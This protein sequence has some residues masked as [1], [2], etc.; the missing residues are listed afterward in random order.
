MTI[1]TAEWDAKDM[2][3]YKKEMILDLLHLTREKM[4][5]DAALQHHADP[6]E[7][8]LFTRIYGKTESI[9]AS[10][11]EVLEPSIYTYDP[12]KIPLSTPSFWSEDIKL[13]GVVGCRNPLN[14]EHRQ[15]LYL[16]TESETD[17]IGIEVAGTGRTLRFKRKI[18]AFPNENRILKSFWLNV[19][20]GR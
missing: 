14:V 11:E 12:N 1:V 17:E 6:S 18:I 8:I 16:D 13:V 4:K 10:L 5:D 9:R 3:S 15:L 20:E 19:K 7:I 2:L